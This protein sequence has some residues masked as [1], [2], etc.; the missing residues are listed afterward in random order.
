[1][2]KKQILALVLITLL[3]TVWLYFQSVNQPPTPP[4][5]QNNENSSETFSKKDSN[6]N[7]P[8]TILKDTLPAPQSD[9]FKLESKYGSRFA[10]LLKGSDQ[11]ITI[12]TE[13][14]KAIIHSKGAVLTYFEL[15][16]YKKW[17]KEPSQL[18]P[19]GELGISALTLEGKRIDTRELFYQFNTSE[20]NIRLGGNRSFSFSAILETEPGQFIEK[21]FTFYGNQYIFDFDVNIEGM[22][23]VLHS[24]GLTLN[25]NDG[26]HYQELNSID[27]SSDAVAMTSLGQATEEIDA[28]GDQPVQASATGSIDFAAVKIKYFSAT[29]IPHPARSFDGTVDME[30]KN[31]KVEHEGAVE[32][33]SL[34]FRL[35]YKGGTHNRSFKIFIGP[36][37]YDIVKPLGLDAE[38]N[39][40]WKWL[41][42][43]IGEFFMLP[44]FKGIHDVVPNYGI[45]II[46]FSILMKLLLYPLSI[47]QMKSAQKMQ[48]LGPEMAAIR[49]R[50]KDD[51]TKQQ[52]ET[53]KLYS[54]YGINP[55]GGCLPLL[56]QMPILYALWAVL[57]TAIDLRQADF[58]LWITDL[59]VP[60]VLFTLP[61]KLI[62]FDQFSG[63]ALAMGI[64]LFIQQKMSVTDP[65]QKSMVYI[66]PVMF[67]LMFSGFPSGLNLYYFMFN[68][69]GILQQ[70]YMN[71]YSKNKPSLADLK[72]APKKEGFLQRKMR[73]AQDIAQSQGRSI[74]GMPDKKQ[75]GQ[76]GQGQRKKKR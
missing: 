63:L 60:D 55:M 61:F 45:A 6:L 70:V 25:W 9:S 37:D 13:L 52:Q 21:K 24:R 62:W 3:L 48:L 10:K 74:P 22:E 41:V 8:K 43:P 72:R 26:L 1:M 73:E 38:I 5:K 51:N 50:F 16:N 64:T 40:G 66:M 57:R 15:K 12:E 14:Y 67:T 47:G 76:R 18:I 65:R 54:E 42:R 56:L 46:I 2:D 39:F 49:E 30:G 11:T 27:E 7:E 31:Y 68:L 35:P 58:F 33:Y 36:L 59:S 17:D 19:T 32:K 20:T 75:Q 69:F 4:Q 29:I 34:S 44:I 23:S 28:S 53:M 71:K